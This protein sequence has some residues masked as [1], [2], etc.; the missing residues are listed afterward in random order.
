MTF[1]IRATRISIAELSSFSSGTG[2]E[3]KCT[4]S[5]LFSAGN[6]FRRFRYMASLRKG[7]NGA[8]VIASLYRTSNNVCRDESASS[9]PSKPF[10]LERFS[11]T[12][13]L[14]RSSMNFSNRGTTVYN[15]YSAISA[16]TNFIRDWHDARIHTSITLLDSLTV[17]ISTAWNTFGWRR[18][19]ETKKRYALYQGRN[20]SLTMSI[21]PSL[22][23]LR[24]SALTTG[25]LMRYSLSAS[26]PISLT[27]SIGS[28]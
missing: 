9:F 8:I 1:C 16:L 4:L 24:D 22:L 25:E 11:L 19:H 5:N 26:A 12:Y 20:T 15:L 10:S 17:S 27:T 28:G 18:A 23:N 21:T 3:T 7:V 2:N 14:V 6:A 13:Q